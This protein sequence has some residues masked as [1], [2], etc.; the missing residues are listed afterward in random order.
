[1]ELTKIVK[2]AIYQSIL[3][4]F[5]IVESK[6]TEMF[7]FGLYRPRV[8]YLGKINREATKF[9]EIIIF[10]VS[11]E[12]FLSLKIARRYNDEDARW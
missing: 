4:F 7:Y 9:V 1:M 11:F 5:H 8:Q 3:V 2:I 6:I 12:I 10:E